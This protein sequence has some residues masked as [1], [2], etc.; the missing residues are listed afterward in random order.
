MPAIDRLWGPEHAPEWARIGNDELAELSA[1]DPKRFPGWAASLPMNAPAAAAREA[2]RALANGANAIQLHTNVDGAPID[3][4]H[5]WPI[6][7]IIEKSGRPIL[8]HPIR[9]REMADYRTETK[10]KY[11]ICS[12]IGWPF[13]TGAAL[14]RLVFSGVMDRYPDLKVI[15]HHLGGIIPYFEGRV[16]HSWDQLGVRT[17]DEDYASLLKRLKKRPF[18]YFKG[19]Y[20]DTALAGARA[21]T[22]CGISFF[23]PDHVLFASDCP[24]DPEKGRGYIRATIEVMESLDLPQADMD[25]ICHRNAERMFGL[26]FVGWAKSRIAHVA[27]CAEIG[28]RSGQWRLAHLPTLR[29]LRISGTGMRRPVPRAHFLGRRMGYSRR[30][31]P[32]DR[33]LH[34]RSSIVRSARAPHP[35]R[36]SRLHAVVRHVPARL[37]ADGPGARLHAAAGAPADRRLHAGILAGALHRREHRAGDRGRLRLG[38]RR[39]WSAACTSRSRRSRTSARA[40][41]AAGKPAVLGGPSVSSA[42][43][44]YPDFDYLHIGEIGDATDDL[45]GRLDAQRRARRP[46]RSRSRP[47]SAL[48]LDQFPLPA[49]DMIPLVALPDRQP[50]VLLRLPVSL[51][52]LR[53]PRRCTAAS[54][55]S[56]RPSSS[57]PSSTPCCASRRARW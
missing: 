13:E 10:S 37:C 12:V 20:G 19:F 18:D 45:I 32:S 4:E 23:T 7:E 35:L 26:R 34:L 56:R 41:H 44:M 54:R 40:R 28:S 48:A 27:E 9:T 30:P 53:H 11:E 6:Y 17:S 22:I 33:G 47:R 8:L 57:R 43:E 49:Y 38:R 39:A 3:E 55:G 16:A 14:A 51:R 29:A 36:V 15:T 25:K 42:P 2:E 24:F 5:F 31:G 1:K 50:A 52:V 46:R 21:P